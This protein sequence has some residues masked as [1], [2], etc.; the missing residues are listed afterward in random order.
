MK[1]WEARQLIISEHNIL[2]KSHNFLLQKY[3]NWCKSNFWIIMQQER[4]LNIP[5]W[6]FFLAKYLKDKVLYPV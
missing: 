1:R 5:I 3:F 6:N 2:N 4:T